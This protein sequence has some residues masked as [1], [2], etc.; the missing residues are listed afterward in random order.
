MGASNVTRLDT[1]VLSYCGHLLTS[2]ELKIDKLRGLCS[3]QADYINWATATGRR[4]LVPPFTDR[5]V[6][7]GQ[8]DGTPAVVNVSFLDRSRYF[9]FQVAPHLSSR[10]W[11]DPVPD[12]LLLR[13][14]GSAG[15]RTQDLWVCS[16]ELWPLDQRSGLQQKLL[17][18]QLF[19]YCLWVAL[20]EKLRTIC[21]A[22][23]FH[24]CL[25]CKR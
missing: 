5:G 8:C 11:V 15:N 4:I 3:P 19:R 17:L 23:C 18:L 9:F 2:N 16:Q 14:F 1:T 13:K 12:P 24:I 7:R 22:F 21:V 6:S 10:A 25:K 20:L